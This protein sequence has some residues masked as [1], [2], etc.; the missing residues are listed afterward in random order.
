MEC[1][2]Q[3]RFLISPTAMTFPDE[4]AWSPAMISLANVQ[5]RYVGNM[6]HKELMGDVGKGRKGSRDVV[7]W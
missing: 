6:T 7:R 5:T 1:N 3:D 2:Y 4:A